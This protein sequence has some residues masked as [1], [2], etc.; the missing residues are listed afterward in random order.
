MTGWLTLK[1]GTSFFRPQI[2]YNQT[3]KNKT[4]LPSHE[5]LLK[6]IRDKGVRSRAHHLSRSRYAKLW[7]FRDYYIERY[8]SQRIADREQYQNFLIANSLLVACLLP[9]CHYKEER[10]LLQW[11]NMAA[12]ICWFDYEGHTCPHCGADPAC[13]ALRLS[14]S[15]EVHHWPAGSSSR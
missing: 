11:F 5:H 9:Q 6:E 2:H 10:P 13:F 7:K 12:N 4:M 1:S 8:S 3:K 14:P 15:L